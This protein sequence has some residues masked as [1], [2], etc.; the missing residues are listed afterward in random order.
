MKAIR[1][2][3]NE[4]TPYLRSKV[5]SLKYSHKIKFAVDLVCGNGRNSK[6][7]KSLGYNVGAVDKF[8]IY[9]S[10][11]DLGS[12]EIKLKKKPDLILCNY[13]FCFLSPKERRHLAKEINRISKVNTYLIVELYPAKQGYSYNTK[14]IKKL[15]PNDVWKTGHIVK[16]RFILQRKRKCF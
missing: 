6:Y 13:V 15:F 4:P 9:G 7:L 14:E 16:D 12:E 3:N 1:I 8:P 11:L 2:N 10:K 5:K